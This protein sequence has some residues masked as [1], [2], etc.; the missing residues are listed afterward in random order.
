MSVN[1]MQ[2]TVMRRAGHS[3]ALPLIRSVRPR[4]FERGTK[5]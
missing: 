2:R 3:I 1:R 5:Q 4:N